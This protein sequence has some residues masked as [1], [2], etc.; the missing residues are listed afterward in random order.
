MRSM[1]PIHRR[2]TLVV[3][4]VERRT[5]LSQPLFGKYV[6]VDKNIKRLLR[7]NP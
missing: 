3:Y 4:V 2:P 7:L 1:P 6:V 5:T